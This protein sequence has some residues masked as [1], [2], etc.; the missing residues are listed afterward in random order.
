MDSIFIT[1]PKKPN[2]IQCSDHRTI[3]LM[4]HIMKI[5]LM[6][7]MERSNNTIEQNIGE[8]QTGFRPKMGTREGIFN[9]R[10]VCDKYIQHNIPLY[11]CFIDYEKA[12]DNVFHT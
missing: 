5:L 8:T 6:I 10:A 9:L 7:I 11:I 1:L 12:F 4:S 3:S 2:A